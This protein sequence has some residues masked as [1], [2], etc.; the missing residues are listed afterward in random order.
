MSSSP[1]CSIKEGI[2]ILPEAVISPTILRPAAS[3]VARVVPPSVWIC[4]SSVSK[5]TPVPPSPQCCI[6]FPTYIVPSAIPVSKRAVPATSNS[7]SGEAVP[8]PTLPVPCAIWILEVASVVSVIVKPDPEF[9]RK[10]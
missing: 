9:T 5:Y 1:V 6:L 4:T 10:S 3:I 7:S 8:I 2:W